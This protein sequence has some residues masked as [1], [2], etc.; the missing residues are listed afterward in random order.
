MN[1]INKTCIDKINQNITLE[2]LNQKQKDDSIVRFNKNEHDIIC[3]GYFNINSS[4]AFKNNKLLEQGKVQ[5][6]QTEQL[7]PLLQDKCINNKNINIQMT[8]SE[9]LKV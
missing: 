6:D 5:E 2:F 3:D 1:L 9:S 8:S 4:L 7:K